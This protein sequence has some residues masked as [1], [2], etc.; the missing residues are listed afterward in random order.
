[1]K[2]GFDIDGVVND[3]D[4]RLIKFVKDTYNVQL[5]SEDFK[6][7]WIEKSTYVDDPELNK[8]IADGMISVVGDIDFQVTAKPYKEAIRGLRIL[9]KAGHTLHFLTNR[10][11]GKE[12]EYKTG[13]WLRQS[14]VRFDSLNHCGLNGMKGMLGRSLHLDFYVDDHEPHLETMYKYKKR[15][16]KGL[17]LFTQPWNIDNIDGSKFVRFNNWDEILRHLG[18]HYKR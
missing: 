12:N 15:W 10:T 16:T 2:L 14:G 4:S 3:L 9:K 5:K 13:K 18:P 17:G 8:T 6:N 11:I 7:Y 1:M